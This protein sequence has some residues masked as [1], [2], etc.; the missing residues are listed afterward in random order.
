MPLQAELLLTETNFMEWI[1]IRK[2]VRYSLELCQVAMPNCGRGRGEF[3]ELYIAYSTFTHIHLVR[4]LLEILPL[5]SVS[6][7]P[8]HTDPCNR[9]VIGIRSI[10][11]E[12]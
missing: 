1:V 9:H 2:F 6:L 12:D 11:P 10:G 8:K 4:R 7:S 5:P 3:N